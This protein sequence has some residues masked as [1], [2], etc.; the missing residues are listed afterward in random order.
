MKFIPLWN[1]FPQL[2]AILMSTE[3]WC[4]LFW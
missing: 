4:H 2:T 3:I 1:L